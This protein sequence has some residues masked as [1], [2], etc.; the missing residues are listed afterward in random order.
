V[1]TG[2]LPCSAL[3]LLLAF[4]AA[5]STSSHPST[6]VVDA[7]GSDEGPGDA[8]SIAC[9]AGF[10]QLPDGIGC[11]PILPASDCPA[12]TMATLGSTTCAPV[13]NR[14]CPA[15]FVADPSGWGCT[16][17]LP[18]AT[19]VGASIEVLGQKTCQPI[20]TCTGTF[21]PANATL[22]VSPT[23]MA[24]ATH[25]Q[26]IG[27]ALAAMTAGAVIAVDAGQYVESLVV[28]QSGTL[29]GRCPTQVI[30][31]NPPTDSAGLDVKG[32]GVT[33]TVTGMTFTG[34]RPGVVAELGSNLTM[35]GDVVDANR[36]VGFLVQGQSTVASLVGTVVRGTLDPN[37]LGWGVAVQTGG[38]LTMTSSAVVGNRELGVTLT[39]SGS[40]ATL[41]QVVVKDTQVGTMG[42]ANGLDVEDKTVLTVTSSAVIA[43]AGVGLA[44][45]SGTANVATSV[46]R[47]TASASDGTAGNGVSAVSGAT[48]SIDSS[49]LLRNREVSIVIAGAGSTAQISN[50]TVTDTQP[51]AMGQFGAGIGAEGGATLTLT[52]SAVVKSLYYGVFLSD[53]MTT[54]EIDH[55][56]VRDTALDHVDGVGRNIDVQDG[57]RGVL[58]STTVAGSIGEALFVDSTMAPAD[59]DATQTVALGGHVGAFVRLGG[60]LELAQCALVGGT[61]VGLYLTADE[62]AAKV[63]SKATVT[64]SVIR[65]TQPIKGDNG[66]GALSGGTLTMT[67][68][69]INN[70]YGGGLWVGNNGGADGGLTTQGSTATL[71]TCVVR[72]T[73]TEPNDAGQGHGVVG[74]EATLVTLLGCTM[75]GNS[76]AGLAF[77]SATALVSGGAISNN[78]VGLDIQ[79]SSTLMQLRAAPTNLSPGEVVVTAD[80][81]FTGNMQ[82]LSSKVLPLPAVTL[83]Q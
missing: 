55:T 79:G 8:A 60:S 76:G 64:D 34:A 3:T 59:L 62:G 49:W 51:N 12:G 27:A 21:P 74:L 5:C 41:S 26:T 35:N 29:V 22:F 6:P 46:I 50:T 24:D 72:N 45:T 69:T 53:A 17:V 82:N 10:Q 83:M 75:T 57:A 15:G 40:T 30:V 58:K 38:K 4:S 2:S 39:G 28:T 77:E 20:G 11:D 56:L 63:H 61:D 67:N 31:S 54:G 48:L 19:C 80:T 18:V 32:A 52:S 33:M 14:K 1:V 70:A 23:A 81:A 9:A 36:D 16:D 44:M 25:F 71:T 68:V 42:V 43:S 66:L 78:E 65:D 37:G 7:G 73:Q 47:D 13:G